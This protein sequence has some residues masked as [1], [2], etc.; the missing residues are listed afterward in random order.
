MIID[1]FR[2]THLSMAEAIDAWRIVPR[3]MV[4]GYGFLVYQVVSWYMELVPY[5]LDGCV[6]DIVEKCI[7]E[8]PATQHSVL[9]SAVIGLGAVMVG[10]YVNTGRKWNEGIKKWDDGS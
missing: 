5:M 8:A 7:I 9:V 2:K 4:A 3:L 10:F 1:G 6:S